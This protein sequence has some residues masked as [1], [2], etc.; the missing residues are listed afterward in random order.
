MHT[1]V[2]IKRQKVKYSVGAEWFKM[3]GMRGGG[4]GKSE[5][6]PSKCQKM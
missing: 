6:L 5:I 2:H 3:V 1:Y 4:K